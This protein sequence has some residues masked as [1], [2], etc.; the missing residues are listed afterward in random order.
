MA[1]TPPGNAGNLGER[2]QHVFLGPRPPPAV[3]RPAKRR[4]L[5]PTL[6]ILQAAQTAWPGD[7]ASSVHEQS[8]SESASGRHSPRS[9]SRSGADTPSASVTD[10]PPA[11]APLL[12]PLAPPPLVVEARAPAVE[13]AD[14]VGDT[15]QP[16]AVAYHT[17]V[18]REHARQLRMQR[19][20]HVPGDDESPYRA[21]CFLCQHTRGDPNAPADA[22]V[23]AFAEMANYLELRYGL[24]EDEAVC[25]EVANIHHRHVIAPAMRLNNNVLPPG[26][27]R[28]TPADVLQHLNEHIQDVTA[29]HLFCMRSLRRVATVLEQKLLI[30]EGGNVPD[31]R[32][33][34]SLTK[35]LVAY[36]RAN[37]KWQK[38]VA[39]RGARPD[40][41]LDPQKMAGR[42]NLQRITPLLQRAATS[43]VFGNSAG[44]SAHR[45]LIRPAFGAAVEPDVD[46]PELGD[47]ELT[48]R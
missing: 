32:A 41:T 6:A 3:V 15:Y 30:V 18:S 1:A 44:T 2:L 26:V 12:L 28:M 5:D 29:N 25:V 21:Y 33:I 24:D 27:L 35:V 19:F 31:T 23:Y 36:E 14:D 46:D 13:M 7:V 17:T 22:G 34:D 11:R 42:T 39:A 45:D 43:S 8:A 37:D 38:M 20:V 4:R 16:L 48:P 9:R 47:P 40:I 10:E